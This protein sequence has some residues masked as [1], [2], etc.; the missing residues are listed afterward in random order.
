MLEFSIN[1]RFIKSIFISFPFSLA[2]YL[3]HF[4]KSRPLALVEFHG[5]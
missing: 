2:T 5:S 1:L 4:L 3:L